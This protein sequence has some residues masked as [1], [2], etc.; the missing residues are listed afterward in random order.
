M[1][2]RPFAHVQVRTYPEF[3]VTC[4]VDDIVVGLWSCLALCGVGCPIVPLSVWAGTLRQ[5]A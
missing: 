1:Y 2:S 3:V 4:T 5:I